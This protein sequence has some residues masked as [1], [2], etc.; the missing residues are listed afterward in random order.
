MKYLVFFLFA[1]LMF[2]CKK[3]GDETVP[4]I[5][6]VLPVDGLQV[7]VL[8]TI[9]VKVEV[10]DDVALSHLQVRL[11]TTDQIAVMPAVERATSGTGGSLELDYVLDDISV[12]S[13]QYYL[14]A[15]I[16]DEA[17][18]EAHDFAVLNVTAVPKELLGVFAALP[19]PGF[20]AIHKIDAAWSTTLLGNYQGDFTDLAVNS[21]WQQVAYTGSV[22]GMF[23]CVSL[24]GVR[25]GWTLNA[26]PSAGPYW[27]SVFANGKDWLVNFRSDGLMKKYSW[28]GS[29]GVTYN[30]N[31]GYHFGSSVFSGEKYFAEM[32]D[33][34]MT[35]RL[36]GVYVSG[37][38]AVQQTVMN[39]DPVVFLPRDATTI[40][41]VGNQNGQGK[42]L[43]YDYDVNGFWE[44]IG[45]P[46]GQVLSATEIDSGTLLIAMD[47]GSIYKFTYS[48]VGLL[49]WHS[50]V[51]QHIRYDEA[52]G[53]VITCEA[54]SIKQYDY[55]GV[56]VLHTVPMSDTAQDIELWYNR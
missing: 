47:N 44:P 31:F 54:L 8:D 29:S 22:S 36:L 23:R 14:E 4:A 43:I 12:E 26:I 37:G 18:N 21:W 27:G 5:E 35:S 34:A 3:E 16:F 48:P 55:P 7:D 39:I 46:S 38:G 20:V 28:S 1:V 49:V 25:P 10:A 17:G 53:T 19:T 33:F 24:D 52:G 9:H 41:V 40:Y 13:G 6:I 32:E 51:A 2:S 56:N 11:M 30:S 50:A 45:L 15:K 42:L